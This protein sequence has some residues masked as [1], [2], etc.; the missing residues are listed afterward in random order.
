MIQGQFGTIQY[1]YSEMKIKL[2]LQHSVKING[3]IYNNCK[4]FLIDW[5]TAFCH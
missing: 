3:S 5:N 2:D 4:L 1:Y